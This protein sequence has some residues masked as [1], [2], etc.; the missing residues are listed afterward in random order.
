[1]FFLSAFIITETVTV[2]VTVTVNNSYKT[3]VR[4]FVFKRDSAAK[5]ISR[6][7]SMHIDFIGWVDG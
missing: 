5:F 7:Q 3:M 4:A 1:M 2:T 6:T